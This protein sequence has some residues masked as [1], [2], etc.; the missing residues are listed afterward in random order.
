VDELRKQLDS[1]QKDEDEWTQKARETEK[2]KD[3]VFYEGVKATDPREKLRCARRVKELDQM[4]RQYDRNAEVLA[5]RKAD[6]AVVLRGLEAALAAPTAEETAWNE[7]EAKRLAEE[8]VAAQIALTDAHL[9]V[10]TAE[11]TRLATASQE[12]EDVQDI[13]KLMEVSEAGEEKKTSTLE[14]E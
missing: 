8:D 9:G 1:L 7:Q 3:A 5:K 12:L 10:T 13:L 11:E 6:G 4:M 2:D 14:R